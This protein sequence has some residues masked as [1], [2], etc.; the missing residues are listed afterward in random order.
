MISKILYN[1]IIQV[2]KK[3]RFLA[4]DSLVIPQIFSCL[5]GELEYSIV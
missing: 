5:A 3:L 1:L 4:V 2:A